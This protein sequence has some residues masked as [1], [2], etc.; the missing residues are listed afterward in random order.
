MDVDALTK[1]SADKDKKEKT[2][3]ERKPKKDNVRQPNLKPVHEFWNVGVDDGEGFGKFPRYG[4][5]TRI[6]DAT[7]SHYD[8]TYSGVK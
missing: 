2:P 7:A 1:A 4:V 3:R 8:W 5:P 6:F